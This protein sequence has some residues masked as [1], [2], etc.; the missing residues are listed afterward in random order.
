MTVLQDLLDEI[1]ALQEQEGRLRQHH[2]S[3]CE[4]LDK[5]EKE[6]DR[7]RVENEDLRR[8]LEDAVREY[9]RLR[10]STPEGMAESALFEQFIARAR[11][12][13]KDVFPGIESDQSRADRWRSLGYDV[14]WSDEVR[15][16]LLARR[17]PDG[18]TYNLRFDTVQEVDAWVAEREKEVKP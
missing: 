16:Y 7:L 9:V 5:K 14:R 11:E 6:V 2:R 1:T 8:E 15:A 12:S 13:G 4:E 10:T 18:R 17:D 3:F